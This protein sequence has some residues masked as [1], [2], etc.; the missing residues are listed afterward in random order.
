MWLPSP[1]L[2][3]IDWRWLDVLGLV[4]V[5][6]FLLMGAYRGMWWQV[7]RLLGIVAAVSVA[8]AAA[9]RLAPQFA[10]AFPDISERVATGI[11]WTLVI[12][13]GL[14]AIALVGR[15]GKVTLDAA[16]MG[17]IDRVGGAL[18]GGLTGAMIHAAFV[19]CLCQTASAEWSVAEVRG[20]TSQR[21]VDSLG[22][23]LPLFLDADAQERLEPWLTRP[24]AR[25]A[26]SSPQATRTT[27]P[28]A[29]R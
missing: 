15:L 29:V 13:L 19:L 11:V 16:H 7:I 26:E 1:C 20:T 6:F 4:V 28:S 12:L 27:T 25:A 24:D 18:A 14:L 9:P 10:A 3:A 5:G 8:R 2:A 17:S 23:K 22:R 21:L